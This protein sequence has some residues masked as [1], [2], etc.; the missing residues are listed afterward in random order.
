MSIRIAACAL[1][2]GTICAIGA[3]QAEPVILSADDLDGV[4]AAGYAYVDGYKNVDIN[5]QIDKDV[6]IYKDKYIYQYVDVYGFY[7]D[8]DGAANCYGY[9]CETITY[10]LT[11]VDATKFMSTSISGSEAAAEPFPI[12]KDG[13]KDD[14]KGHDAK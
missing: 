7:A 10:A 14:Y 8:A 1:T 6:K 11:D 2:L 12:F 3:A 9:G 5:E 4:T 13:Y